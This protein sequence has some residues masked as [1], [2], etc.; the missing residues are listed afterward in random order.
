MS[1]DD[2]IHVLWAKESKYRPQGCKKAKAANNQAVHEKQSIEAQKQMASAAIR[3]NELIEE[4]NTMALF[5]ADL[6]DPLSIEYF[7]LKKTCKKKFR[8]IAADSA[9]SDDFQN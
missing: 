7:A 1:S 6:K 4:Q 2:D 9:A 8:K 3:R 5:A